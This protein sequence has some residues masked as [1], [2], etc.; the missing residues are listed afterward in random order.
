MLP[1]IKKFFKNNEGDIILVVGI[2]LIS[3]ISFG[4]GWLMGISPGLESKNKGEVK[5][6][7]VLLEDLQA[8]TGIVGELKEE[9]EKSKKEN[10]NNASKNENQNK[11][12]D[13]SKEQNEK[14]IV[15]SKNGSVYH[16]TWC[17]GAKRIKEENKIYFNSKEEAEAAGYRPAK[18]CE[19][20]LE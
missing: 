5:I 1:Q 16:Y 13:K 8:E 10:Q 3:L 11:N 2:I 4:G 18:N 17:P 7:E 15:A 9:N 6:E 12:E 20:L 19:G 14:Q